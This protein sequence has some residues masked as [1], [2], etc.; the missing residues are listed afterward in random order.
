MAH[1]GQEGRFHLIGFFRLFQG[2]GQID[3]CFL[4]LLDI[5]AEAVYFDGIIIAGS[6]YV[7]VLGIPEFPPLMTLSVKIISSSGYLTGGK[8]MIQLIP[9]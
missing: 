2:L 9:V 3:F 6:L 1:I 7:G 4:D 8:T 5:K